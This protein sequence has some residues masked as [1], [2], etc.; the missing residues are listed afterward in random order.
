MKP[1]LLHITFLFSIIY[2]SG[3]GNYTQLK[4]S[5]NTIIVA[6]GVTLKTSRE[7]YD[8]A[9][10]FTI[11]VEIANHSTEVVEWMPCNGIYLEIYQGDFLLDKQQLGPFCRNAYRAK[12]P[13]NDKGVH[14]IKKEYLLKWVADPEYYPDRRYRLVFPKFQYLSRQQLLPNEDRYS[15]F[16]TII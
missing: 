15:N 3:C 5:E 11:D 10:D 2:L 6:S 12:I 13:A 4:S 7:S 8:Y 9:K 1:T 16:F 14:I